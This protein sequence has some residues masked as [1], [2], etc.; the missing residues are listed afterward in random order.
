VTQRL[1][2]YDSLLT[3][4]YIRATALATL[5]GPTMIADSLAFGPEDFSIFWAGF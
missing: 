2:T 5:Y 3:K 4:Y 1:P